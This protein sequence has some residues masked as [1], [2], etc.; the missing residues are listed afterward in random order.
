MTAQHTCTAAAARTSAVSVLLL[1]VKYHSAAIAVLWRYINALL[2]EN[3]EEKAAAH[4]TQIACN[5]EV[6]V[7]GNSSRS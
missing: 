4:Y 7:R 6:I 5:Y 2:H 3:I 1:R